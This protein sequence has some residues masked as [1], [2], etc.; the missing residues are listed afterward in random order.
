M[1]RLRRQGDWNQNLSSAPA[2][3]KMV[4]SC[5]KAS[6]F[7]PRRSSNL[8]SQTFLVISNQYISKTERAYIKKKL[9]SVIIFMK[10][11]KDK[12]LEKPLR[13]PIITSKTSSSFSSETSNSRVRP[14]SVSKLNDLEKNLFA[15]LS[16]Y[17]EIDKKNVKKSKTRK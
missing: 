13:L 15:H 1:I 16:Q 2:P 7:P 9:S 10:Q 4:C 12:N 6:G 3:L 11:S 5:W 17:D 8:P 14:S